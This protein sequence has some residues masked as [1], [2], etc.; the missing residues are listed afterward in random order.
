M[1][2]E[3]FPISVPAEV[4]AM[5]VA[6]KS[7][8]GDDFK[9]TLRFTMEYLKG[10]ELSDVQ[11]EKLIE[12]TS[13]DE[14]KVAIIFT[15]CFYVL[16]AALRAR[17]K[18]AVLKA[19][20]EQIKMLSAHVTEL[21]S[22]FSSSRTLAENSVL[23]KSLRQPALES[24]RWRVDITISSGSMVRVMKPSILMEMTLTD[25]SVRTFEVSPDQ[26]D[27]LR[28]NVAGVLKDIQDLE[29]APVLKIK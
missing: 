12:T 5:V 14:D 1:S 10:R 21:V 4:K 20:L 11:F 23:A 7:V 27:V 26:F 17:M 18:E 16:R 19:S 24:L 3:L 29:K 13:L 15:G 28:H 2:N 6:V 25:G 22:T 8:S 9:Q